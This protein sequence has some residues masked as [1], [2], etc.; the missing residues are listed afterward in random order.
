MNTDGNTVYLAKCQNIMLNSEFKFK[1]HVNKKIN[2]ILNSEKGGG[3]GG[4]KM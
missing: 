4:L 2:Q 3:S 1:G